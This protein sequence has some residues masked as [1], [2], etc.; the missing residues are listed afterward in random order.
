MLVRGFKPIV[1]GLIAVGTVVGASAPAHA[2]VPTGG[3]TGHIVD[4]SGHGVANFAVKLVTGSPDPDDDNPYHAYSAT[5]DSSG[6]FTVAQVAPAQYSL[7]DEE[8]G[9][10][11]ANHGWASVKVS[12]GVTATPTA[13]AIKAATVSGTVVSSSDGTPIA[14]Q[15]VS[16]DGPT[17]TT[18]TTGKF[19]I[20]VFPGRV[21]LSAKSRFWIDAGH[22]AAF[23]EGSTSNIGTIALDPA[24]IITTALVSKSGRPIG[25]AYQ[26]AVVDGCRVDNVHPSTCA[27]VDTWAEVGS[28]QLSAGQHTVRYEVRSP[29][30]S[31][32]RHVTRSVTVSAGVETSIPD[33]VFT[34][35]D[36]V[37]RPVVEKTTYRHGRAVVLKIVEGTYV[38][39]A[40][41][42][43]PVTIRFSRHTVSPTKTRWITTAAGTSVLIA[44]MPTKWSTHASLNVHVTVHG[45]SIYAAATSAGTKVTRVQ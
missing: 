24:G 27:G 25:S 10:F 1:V 28:L 30:T 20:E 29:S 6:T 34:T 21:T 45:N 17:A 18:D 11:E 42:R 7:L 44:T 38:D 2:E 43:L 31:I 41:P 37:K 5:T 12:A 16:A 39:G 14:G 13:V 3:V 8:S 22:T 9:W 23:A 32:V 4:S 35:V 33:V 19:T 26:S 40:K 36:P 15:T